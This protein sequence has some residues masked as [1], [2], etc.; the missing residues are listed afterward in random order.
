MEEINYHQHNSSW[1][2]TTLK[3]PI[4]EQFKSAIFYMMR[5]TVL[6]C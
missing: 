6:K 4:A 3:K 1:C 5:W 2:T